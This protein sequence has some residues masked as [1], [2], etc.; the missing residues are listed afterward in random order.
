V[1]EIITLAQILSS[2]VT[3]LTTLQIAWLPIPHLNSH[4]VDVLLYSWLVATAVIGS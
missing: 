3:A 4:I 1:S 2:L